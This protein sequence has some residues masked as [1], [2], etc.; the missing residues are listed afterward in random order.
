[1]LRRQILATL[2]V[3]TGGWLNA[4]RADLIDY[5]KK[6]DG[7]FAWKLKDKTE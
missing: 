5:V 7:A 6:Q 2:M 3:L 4:A 1:M